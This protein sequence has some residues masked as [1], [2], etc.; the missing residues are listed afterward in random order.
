[1][2]VVVV[3]PQDHIII[4]AHFYHG[5]QPMELLEVSRLCPRDT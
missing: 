1:V 2:L 3:P 5:P 4:R